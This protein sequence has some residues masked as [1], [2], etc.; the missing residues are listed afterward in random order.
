MRRRLLIIGS[1]AALIAALILIQANRVPGP[2]LKIGGLY[3]VQKDSDPSF[4][5]AKVLALDEAVHVRV[6]RR[7]FSQRP[8]GVDETTLQTA[9]SFDPKAPAWDHIPISRS[10][11]S[12]WKPKWLGQSSVSKDELVG[13]FEWRKTGGGV[14]Q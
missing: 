11:F 8:S 7:R 1:A 10:A 13:Y 3:A 6:Y 4:S 9:S 5:V 2:D 12:A 14:W